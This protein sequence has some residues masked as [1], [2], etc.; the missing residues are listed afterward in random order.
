MK[1]YISVDMEGITGLV[2]QTFVDS[3]GLNYAR[4]QKLMTDEVNHVIET[5][6]QQGFKEIIVNDSHSKMNNLLIER[7]HPEAQLISGDVKPFSMVQGL[8]DTYTG[9][10]FLGYHSRAGRKGVLSHT[11]IFGVRNMYINDAPVG[12]L[13]FN[14]YVAGHYGVPLLMVAGDDGVAEEAEALIPGITTA[15]VKKQMSR[16]SALC[17]TPEKAGWLLR[18]KTKLAIES[19]ENVAPL[20]PPEN[21]V[22]TIEFANYGQAEW[23]HLLPGTELD[24]E[25]PLVRYKAQDIL[26]AYKAMIVMTELAMK[27]KFC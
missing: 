2:D 4:G 5:A 26:E 10:I 18:E 21:P 24:G 11:M 9:A 6:F 19:R 3:T 12:E 14:A 1:L 7:L 16:T 22:L 15:V 8:D 25:A 23:A 20:T 13:G 17:L 27:A